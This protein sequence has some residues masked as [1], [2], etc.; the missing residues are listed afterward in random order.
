[1]RIYSIGTRFTSSDDDCNDHMNCQ[2]QNCHDFDPN[3]DVV[4]V[5]ACM[6]SVDFCTIYQLFSLTA[7]HQSQ[8]QI[9]MRDLLSSC[10]AGEYLIG[11]VSA[12]VWLRID[13]CDEH[14]LVT[15]L[16][17]LVVGLLFYS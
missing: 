11:V 14:W 6:M 12:L 16:I 7:D 4:M 8:N 17:D 2:V 10:A 9:G 13:W 1:M 3:D 15:V 5:R